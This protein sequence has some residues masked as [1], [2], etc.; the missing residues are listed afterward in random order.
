MCSPPQRDGRVA[1]AILA[2]AGLAGVTEVHAIGGAQAIAAMAYGTESVRRVDKIFG[3]GNAYVTA[4]KLAV[5]GEASIDMPAGPSEILSLTDGSVRAAWVAADLRAQAEHAPDARAVLVSTDPAF[6]ADVRDLVDGELAEQVRVL[7][8]A[9]MDEAV[10]FA[11]D[12]APEHLTVACP[13]PQRW[14]APISAPAPRFLR[15]H[16]PPAAGDAAPAANHLR[17]PRAARRPL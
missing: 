4:A 17:P 6:A 1:L 13:A 8:A 14:L 15:P 9:R 2:A 7:T 3:P 11:N 16:P 12:F 10:A 5:F